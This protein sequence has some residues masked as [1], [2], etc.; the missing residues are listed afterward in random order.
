MDDYFQPMTD[1]SLSK[2][3]FR[4]TITFKVIMSIDLILWENILLDYNVKIP[5]RLV[6]FLNCFTERIIIIASSF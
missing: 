2:A 5:I 6:F 4:I 1:Y 3:K